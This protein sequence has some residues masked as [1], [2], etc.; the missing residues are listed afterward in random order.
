M[1][2]SRNYFLVAL[3]L[4]LGFTLGLAVSEIKPHLK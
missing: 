1:K 2:K 3:C 4:A